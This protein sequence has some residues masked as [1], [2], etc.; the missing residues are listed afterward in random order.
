MK[1]I[2]LYLAVTAHGFGHTTRLAAVVNTLLQ[3]DPNIL[4]IFVTPAPRWL[5]ERYVQG[6]FL[7][8]PRR[9][10]VGVVQP[11]GLQADL[12]ATLRALREF[13]AGSAALIRAEADF[14]STQRV[15]LILADVPPIATAIAQAAGIPCW[16]A[17]NFG[18][19]FIYQ[20]YGPEFQP[21][22][23]WIQELYSQCDRLF[24][25]PFSEPMGAFPRQQLVGL[26]GGEPRFSAAAVAAQLGLSVERPTALFTFGGLGLQGFPYERLQDFPEWQFLTFDPAAPSLP[27]L[28]RLNGQQWRPVDLMP[29]CRWVVSKPGYGTLAEALRSHTP[30]A[31]ITRSGFAESPLLIEGLQRYGQHSVLSP[32]QFFQ[33]SWDFLRDPPIPP[34]SSEQLDL[35]GNETIA[36]AIL[37]E[38]G[39]QVT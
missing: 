37:A 33:G 11:D 3:Q 14:V 12:P 2:P 35:Q 27:N 28:T 10:D 13:Q 34:R 26:T 24:R 16:M 30:M 9:L 4:P 19:D 15:P 17:S 29:L 21:F 6:K 23:T 8:R 22:V 18:W 39:S 25:L 1:P 32:A 31:C 36:A 38:A 20:D 5:L 7:H